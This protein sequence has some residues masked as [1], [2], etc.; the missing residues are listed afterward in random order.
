MRCCPLIKTSTGIIRRGVAQ[1]ASICIYAAI[2]NRRYYHSYYDDHELAVFFFLFLLPL[3][4]SCL[5]AQL[6][7]TLYS[8]R[9]VSFVVVVL[10]IPNLIVL[11]CSPVGGILAYPVVSYLSFFFCVC[12]FVCVC[13]ILLQHTW[14]L[15]GADLKSDTWKQEKKNFSIQC[16]NLPALLASSFLL[17]LLSVGCCG[18]CSHSGRKHGREGEASSLPAL[19]PRSPGGGRYGHRACFSCL[20]ICRVKTCTHICMCIYIYHRSSSLRCV[21]FPHSSSVCMALPS[22]F[23][24]PSSVFFFY[25]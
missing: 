10:R 25:F 22:V 4:L 15:P 11:R 9:E 6:F 13:V 5:S 24:A 19:Q 7:K 12:V 16:I 18:V 20:R 1:V 8:A 21:A 3:S 17:F 23:C 14:N 2:T